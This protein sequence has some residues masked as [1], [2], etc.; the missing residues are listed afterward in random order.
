MKNSVKTRAKNL[1]GRLAA[2]GLALL[3]CLGRPLPAFAEGTAI[4]ED[5]SAAWKAEKDAFAP[6]AEPAGPGGEAGDAVPEAEAP[7]GDAAPLAASSGGIGVPDISWFSET[8]Y[9]NTDSYTLSG[10]DALAGLAALVSGSA[11]LAGPYDFA[12]K[13]LQLDSSSDALSLA[14]YAAGEGWAPIG[15]AAAPFRG[16]FHGGGA[17]LTGLAINRPL[18]ESQGLF[19]VA[20]APAGGAA[21]IQALTLS[22]VLVSGGKNTGGLVGQGRGLLMRDCALSG[23]VL[24]GEGT[25]GLA[26]GLEGGCLVSGCTVDGRV[27]GA[28]R[29]GGVA[30][31]ADAAADAAPRIE[32]CTVSAEVAGGEDTGGVAG[33]FEGLMQH[34]EVLGGVSGLNNT[35]GLA[36]SLGGHLL[37]QDAQ[38]EAPLEGVVRASASC[39]EVRGGQGVGGIAGQISDSGER[40][41]LVE[42]CYSTGAVRGK[43]YTG[44]IAGRV[45]GLVQNCYSTGNITGGERT[46]GVAGSTQVLREPAAPLRA[47][48]L[49]CYA[50]G[51]VEGTLYV[52]GICGAFPGGRLANCV[53][54][55]AEVGG[56]VAE[57][58]AR[59]TGGGMAQEY[60][61]EA[62]YAFAGTTLTLIQ[63]GGRGPFT[64]GGEAEGADKPGGAGLSAVSLLRS[65][66]QSAPP[67]NAFAAAGET[68]APLW[69]TATPLPGL[70][71]APGQQA[72]A[73]PPHLEDELPDPPPGQPPADK[74]FVD[75]PGW[76]ETGGDEIYRRWLSGERLMAVYYG[77]DS[78]LSKSW[79][80]L[81][82]NW[83]E[84]T[85]ISIYAA[86]ADEKNALWLFPGQFRP[87]YQLPLVAFADGSGGLALRT[88]ADG[89]AALCEG[90]EA[91]RGP[92]ARAGSYAAVNE[93]TLAGYSTA[94]VENFLKPETNI[95]SGSAAVKSKSAE[96]A[97]GAA[98]EAAKLAAIHAWVSGTLY[99]DVE[100]LLRATGR[101]ADA[102]S[103]LSQASRG[104]ARAT[105]LGYANLT[106][107]LCRAAG[108]PCRVVA[109]FSPAHA[110]AGQAAAFEAAYA[111]YLKSGDYEAFA[112]AAAPLRNHVWNAAFV[113]G[114]WCWL[115]AA[116]DSGNAA[117]G[118][119]AKKYEALWVPGAAGQ[120]WLGPG[121]EAFAAS[122]CAWD[123]DALKLAT[124]FAL[125]SSL[126][127]IPKGMA[128]RVTPLPAPAGSA[129]GFDTAFSWEM[130]EP[131]IASVN[132]EGLVSAIA[133]GKTTLRLSA[134]IGGK[135]KTAT[136][137]IVVLEALE[138]IRPAESALR[139]EPGV[140]AQLALLPVPAASLVPQGVQWQLV[141]GAEYASVDG[142][143][144][145]LALAPGEARIRAGLPD[146]GGENFTAEFRVE[147]AASP[148]GVEMAAALALAPG[149]AQVLEARVLPAGT[150]RELNWHSDD[151]RV[152]LVAPGEAGAARV[153]ALRPGT[154]VL[155]ASAGER[156]A[157]CTV[158][159]AAPP[160]PA[161]SL[162][163]SRLLLA[164]GPVRLTALT[165]NAAARL[166]YRLFEAGTRREVADFESVLQMPRLVEDTP[167]PPGGSRVL[168]ELAP[169]AGAAP[170]A[171]ILRVGGGQAECWA[172]CALTLAPPRES[173][174]PADYAA[175]FL[176]SS[177]ATLWTRGGEAPVINIGQSRDARIPVNLAAAEIRP[178]GGAA[179]ALRGVFGF[180]AL[181]G[182]SFALRY[183]PPAKPKSGYKLELEAVLSLSGGQSLV[184][185]V[186]GKLSVK[187]NTGKP[188]LTA[189]LVT[190][191]AFIASASA[192]EDAALR[193]VKLQVNGGSPTA[194]R[195]QKG[196]KPPDWLSADTN[197]GTVTV[198]PGSAKKSATLYLEAMLA[199]WG[200]GD[201]ADD[202]NWY[203]L[204][205][206]AARVYGKPALKL[207]ATRVPFFLDPARS[208]GSPLALKPQNASQS[209]ARLGVRGLAVAPEQAAAFEV[210]DFDIATG[211]FRLRAAPGANPAALK[212][213]VTLLAAV[214][215]TSQ[216]VP[217]KLNIA[218]V[219]AATQVKLKASGGTFGLNPNLPDG[220]VLP[221]KLSTNVPGYDLAAQP[222]TAEV[223]DS[224]G[225]KKPPSGEHAPTAHV[226]GGV[227]TLRAGAQTAPGKTYKVKL[228]LPQSYQKN[229]QW[230]SHVLTLT[231][232]TAKANAKTKVSFT[233]KGSV[234][235]T[236]GAAVTLTA[237][238]T[239]CAQGF[240]GL[241]AFVLYDAK[242]RPLPQEAAAGFEIR[243][244]GPGAWRVG[245]AAGGAPAPGG[246][247]L[248]IDPAQSPLASGGAPHSANTVKFTVKATAPKLILSP[249]AVT[250]YKSDRQ[251][252]G[253]FS[254]IPADAALEVAELLPANAEKAGFAFT[255][256]ALGGGRYALVFD[257]EKSEKTLKGAKSATVVL[258]LRL[259]GNPGVAAKVR[260]KVV[261]KN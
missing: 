72:G 152:A 80:A 131:G 42:Q 255:T 207:S 19:G 162:G 244:L 37:P 23:S 136:V 209:L 62:N 259:A 69:N 97:A 201:A 139:L 234:D 192:A 232:K 33:H 229:G 63:D 109:G 157:V 24:G 9:N 205:V 243:S 79:R 47:T 231:V 13:W 188:S 129:F 2:L 52:G 49:A 93:R 95:Q 91:W 187:V 59:V 257:H 64:P 39:G 18:A 107:A 76:I 104:A 67:W 30:G 199:G 116:L 81:F 179:S 217:L 124:G 168:I 73:A 120:T 40:L 147:V 48:L 103:L 171:Y 1:A 156:S 99:Y 153:T 56:S 249:G 135:Q 92:G 43:G 111:E 5:D 174:N 15:T 57:I 46:G 36:G 195:L 82:S 182:G 261:V 173:E 253:L 41:S 236:T 151:E 125:E 204:R 155:T 181:D 133:P 28:G 71:Q 246:Y 22:G 226:G 61:L 183:A 60:S 190:V 193:T 127:K 14:A 233:A 3:M 117:Y 145:V 53:A 256:R 70:L 230:Q 223:F 210:A 98:G 227:L 138:G 148:S 175:I 184:L 54:L 121:L 68:G 100:S 88:G 212:G 239:N 216:T 213:S 134:L 242:G 84:R 228:S 90:F 154:A 170:G 58:T 245:A 21:S 252:E 31:R 149:E 160:P 6:Q 218:Q 194:L 254:L 130:A 224:G 51:T 55:C 101:A 75:R 222:L 251:R 225:K 78:T 214:D 20:E 96:L 206:K 132:G 83:M 166:T 215:G 146:A 25:G 186:K 238:Y 142:L 94:G 115:D 123:A 178:K 260:L 161:I 141:S 185:P 38:T 169:A 89:A 237:K 180:S 240:E 106:A 65:D 86:R 172:E 26:G 118:D 7:L 44:G 66:R 34:C 137:S 200:N 8:E 250:L 12:G 177:S 196:K 113:N 85:G 235:L 158:T 258:N 122:H 197:A 211:A 165:E 105:G 159:V 10:A 74:R 126:I 11:G 140:S 163:E 248:G 27:E 35:G 77:P 4:Y 208:L 119:G 220:E 219:S 50:S 203:P 45:Y 144:K 189:A 17:E 202:A 29:T 102:S 247:R 221:V 191:D 114:A 112:Q 32:E 198:L 110:S 16:S 176:E 241:P 164:G 128:M 87:E 150:G 167:L 143:G 108:I